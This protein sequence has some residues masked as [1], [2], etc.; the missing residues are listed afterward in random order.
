VRQVERRPPDAVQERRL[1]QGPEIRRREG[2]EVVV[3]AAAQGPQFRLA[4][5]D[6]RQQERGVES[7][8]RRERAV[9]AGVRRPVLAPGAGGDRK[10]PRVRAAEDGG[11]DVEVAPRADDRGLCGIPTDSR[12]LQLECSGTI[13]GGFLSSRQE[14]GSEDGGSKRI[15]GNEFDL[16]AERDF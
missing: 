7:R 3:E 8:G 12:Y 1:V 11:G 14:V 2:Q 6:R 4:R 16:T 15:V 13:F 5:D 9:V 10:R